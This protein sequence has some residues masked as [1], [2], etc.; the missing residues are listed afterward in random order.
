MKLNENLVL[1]RV[2]AIKQQDN[3]GIYQQEEWRS[4]EPKG[5]VEAVADD[6]NFC[7]VGDKVFFERY[8]S[9]S[10]PEDKDLRLCREDS[11][12]GVYDA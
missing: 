7:K 6:V 4:K 5:V 1:I 12:L 2:D 8:S 10:V 3:D 11:I 9:I